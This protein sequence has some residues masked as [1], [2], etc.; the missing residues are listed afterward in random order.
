MVTVPV[1]TAGLLRDAAVV[2]VLERLWTAEEEQ[3]R[4]SLRSPTHERR[5]DP[6]PFRYP[7]VGF[8]LHAE[9]AELAYMLVRSHGARLVLDVACSL[10]VSTLFLA[11]ALRDSGGGRVVAVE[12][13]P[14]K[15]AAARHHL[16]EAGLGAYV[17]FHEGDARVT[18]AQRLAG[19]GRT[20]DF[21]LFDGWPAHGGRS[22]ARDVLEIVEPHLRDGALLFDDNG[23]ADYLAHVRDPANG[24]RSLMLPTGG[25]AELSLWEGTR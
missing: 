16:E 17:E 1:S 24:Y 5:L 10:G 18:V 22:L 9:Q 13:V 14:E 15:L 4:I 2:A 3:R 20:V 25:G 8:S 11:A 12:V 23:E 19:T 21:V 6:D 7:D